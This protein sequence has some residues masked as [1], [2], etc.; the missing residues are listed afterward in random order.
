LCERYALAGWAVNGEVILA[1]VSRE[2]PTLERLAELRRASGTATAWRRAFCLVVLAELYA[3]QGAIELARE[4]LVMIE[5]HERVALLAPEIERVEA[6]LCLLQ[7]QP[8][9]EEAA[10]HFERAMAI[11]RER[12]ALSFELRATLGWARLLDRQ[13]RRDE[14]RARLGAVYGQFSEGRDTVDPTAAQALLSALAER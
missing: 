10:H 13:G 5:P 14:A 6:E 11:A 3:A 1:A 7:P 8:A 9:S 12:E 4:T 2:A